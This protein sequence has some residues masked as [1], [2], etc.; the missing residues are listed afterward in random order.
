MRTSLQPRDN[1]SVSV[2]CAAFFSPVIRNGNIRRACNNREP[3][4]GG[5]RR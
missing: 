1:E 5:R 2:T 4:R 3:G